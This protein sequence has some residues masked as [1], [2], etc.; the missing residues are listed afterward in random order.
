MK[1][2]I[3]SYNNCKTGTFYDMICV[4]VAADRIIMALLSHLQ[5][6]RCEAAPILFAVCSLGMFLQHFE[7]ETFVRI[8]NTQLFSA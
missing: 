1:Q 4:H 2:K 8:W 7:G 6:G 3:M 5:I